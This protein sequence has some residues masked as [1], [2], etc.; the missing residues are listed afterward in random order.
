MLDVEARRNDTR[1]V[2]MAVELNY[3]FARAMVIN[4]LKFANVS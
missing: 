2:E 1:F 4:D 3:N